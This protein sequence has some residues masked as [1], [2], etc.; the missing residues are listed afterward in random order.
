MGDL[1]STRNVLA[2]SVG[3]RAQVP[4]PPTL[5]LIQIVE[6]NGV[7]INDDDLPHNC[8]FFPVN[9]SR[10]QV[11]RTAKNQGR[12]EGRGGAGEWRGREELKARILLIVYEE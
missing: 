3:S 2:C 1:T 5:L 11:I 6:D 12:E 4:Q 10:G 9:P 7:I 8:L